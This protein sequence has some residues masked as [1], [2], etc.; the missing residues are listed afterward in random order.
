MLLEPKPWGLHPSASPDHRTVYPATTTWQ[1]LQDRP[2]RPARRGDPTQLAPRPV[3]VLMAE[4]AARNNDPL[5]TTTDR[6]ARPVSIA[7]D[8]Q[9]RFCSAAA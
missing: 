2:V 5:W 1:N 4:L 9:G 8:N 3:A 6:R 7:R